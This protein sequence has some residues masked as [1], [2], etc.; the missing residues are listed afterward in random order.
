MTLDQ[1]TNLMWASSQLALMVVVWLLV[2]VLAK[3]VW[4]FL[5]HGT[6]PDPPDIDWP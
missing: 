2:A 5:A 3:F 4:V 1:W 6:V